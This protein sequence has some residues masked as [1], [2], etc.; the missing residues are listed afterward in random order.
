[1]SRL[2]A[3]PDGLAA[4]DAAG[5]TSG[6]RTIW[7]SV[8]PCY[9]VA[10]PGRCTSVSLDTLRL[11]QGTRA[12]IRSRKG[13]PVNMKP[14]GEPTLADRFLPLQRVGWWALLETGG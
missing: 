13:K 9:E 8:W 12:A 10:T 1:M 4:Q 3:A 2:S 14:Q 7:P 6:S 11:V 5:A